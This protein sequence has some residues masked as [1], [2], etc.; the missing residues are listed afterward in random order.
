[1]STIGHIL[2][3]AYL[4]NVAINAVCLL[5]MAVTEGGFPRSKRP[6]LLG[7]FLL[8]VIISGPFIWVIAEIHYQLW[9]RGKG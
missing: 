3:Y 1:M 4:L 6:W 5:I 7:L 9:K 2:L 8:L